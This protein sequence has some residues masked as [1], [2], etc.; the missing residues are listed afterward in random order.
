MGTGIGIY[1]MVPG[2]GHTMRWPSEYLN[3]LMVIH[4]QRQFKT[5]T[6]LT[7]AS[8]KSVSTNT[9]VIFFIANLQN[10]QFQSRNSSLFRTTQLFYLDR[11]R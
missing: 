6:L 7:F 8:E 4:L 3:L 9:E 1:C 2:P 11:Y 5:T 10:T